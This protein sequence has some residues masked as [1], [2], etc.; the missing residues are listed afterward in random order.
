MVNNPSKTVKSWVLATVLYV[1]LSSKQSCSANAPSSRR[2]TIHGS[3][4]SETVT[5]MI[6]VINKSGLAQKSRGRQPLRKTLRPL[7]P[8]LSVINHLSICAGPP[9]INPTTYDSLSQRTPRST[10]QPIEENQIELRKHQ[11][12][13]SPHVHDVSTSSLARSSRNFHLGPTVARLPVCLASP[14][15]CR[16]ATIAETIIP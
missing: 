10:L 8:D 7:L 15:T 13:H 14:Q 9:R 4:K 11:F 12:H 1:Q 3:S 2:F 16:C 5:E 6:D